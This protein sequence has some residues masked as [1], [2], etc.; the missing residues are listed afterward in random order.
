MQLES[1]REATL[2]GQQ[3]VEAIGPFLES[4]R[5]LRGL[6]DATAHELDECWLA[7]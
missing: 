5:P 1:L 4:T 6:P 3:I 7:R 2:V